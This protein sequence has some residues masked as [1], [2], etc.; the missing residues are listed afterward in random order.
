[1]RIAVMGAG[2]LGGYIGARLAAADEDVAFVARGH[3]LA[4]MRSD[5]LRVESPYGNLHLPKVVATDAP[6]DL[7]AV[8]LVLFTVKLWDTDAAAA[9]A[10]PLV[11]PGTLVVTLQN[12]IGNVDLIARHLPRAQVLS[13]LTYI[14]AVVK[15]PGVI[16]NSGGSKRLVV[17][18]AGGDPTIAAFAASCGRAVGLDIELTDTIGR[19]LWEKFI[20]MSAN[21]A[22]SSLMRSTIGPILSNPESRAFFRQL[23]EEGIAVARATGNPIGEGFADESMTFFARSLGLRSSMAEDLERGRRLEL[24]WLGRTSAGLDATFPRPRRRLPGARSFMP[25]VPAR[26]GPE[27]RL[28]TL[29]PAI[30]R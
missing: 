23:V 19:Q 16:S 13:G 20:H 24:P 7:G 27:R 14:P 3:H 8:D 9:A 1:M 22:A 29:R 10:A 21:A 12:G 5:G 17:D 6:A 11:G 26:S 28:M 25:T 2:G 4:A 30:A 18:D 15:A